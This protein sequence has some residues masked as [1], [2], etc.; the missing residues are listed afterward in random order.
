LVNNKPDKVL[1]RW[2]SGGEK[3]DPN[4]GIWMAV[5]FLLTSATL[6]YNLIHHEWMVGIVFGF[7][8]IVLIWYFFSSSKT[9]DITMANN[10]IQ[11][12]NLFYDFENIKGYW[13]SDRTGT[14]YLEPKKRTGLV[15]SFPM[16][17]KSIEEIKKNLPDYLTEIEDRGEDIIDR[18]SGFLHM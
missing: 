10:G 14:F 15:I 13:H 17:N 12:N 16:G 9:V 18:I 3:K 7:L 6:V 8:I 5:L 11:I 2:K 1:L 4:A